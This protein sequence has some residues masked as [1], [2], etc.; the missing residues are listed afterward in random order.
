MLRRVKTMKAIKTI[1]DS[2][3]K[4]ESIRGDFFDLFKHNPIPP[5]EMLNNLGLFIN[6]QTLSRILFMNNLYQKVLNTH[7][8]IIEF[9]VRWGQN[10]SLFSNFRGM[11]EPYN[12]SRT[13]YGFDTFSGFPEID[14]KDG[15][16]V[17]TA[18]YSVTENYKE[19]LTKILEY[20]QNESPI[21]HINK[22]QLIEGNASQTIKTFLE[23]KP[24]IIISLAYFD[25]D[26]YQP[27]KDCLQAILPYCT[28][29]TILAFDELNCQY[30]PD[31]TV[32]VRE[33]LDLTKYRLQR[34][35]QNPYCSYIEL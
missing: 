10:L 30:F 15:N 25:F 28:K 11:Y 19:Y 16:S 5:Y 22:F 20:H 13:I 31:E 27:T 23:E 33:L 17:K 35:T 6:R 21:S 24:E 26:L 34:D 32:A 12:Y 7:G 3:S 1:T 4:E 18:N 29:G 8:V 2:T 9:G 14:V